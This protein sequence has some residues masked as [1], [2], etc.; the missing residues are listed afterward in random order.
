MKA[1][2]KQ[3][4]TELTDDELHN[5]GRRLSALDGECVELWRNAMRQRCPKH[6]AAYRAIQRRGRRVQRAYVAARDEA[7]RR[8]WPAEWRNSAFSVQAACTFG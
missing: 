3:Q 4:L 1:R 8:R 2:L 7:L 5:L 6:S